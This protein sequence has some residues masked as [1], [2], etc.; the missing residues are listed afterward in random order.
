M[1]IESRAPA[2]VFVA[3]DGTDVGELGEQPF[4]ALER[5]LTNGRVELFIDAHEARGPSI[6]V[7][8]EWALWLRKHR[9]RLLHVSMLTGSRLVELSV[10]FAS[11]FAELGDS[12]RSYSDRC[13][14]EGAL[15][16]A[17]GNARARCST[18]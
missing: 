11:A 8:G 7:S 1:L 17:V 9:D 3:I 6:D 13:A 12:M 15:S 16:N 18:D 14:F 2:V 5:R 4:R 10:S